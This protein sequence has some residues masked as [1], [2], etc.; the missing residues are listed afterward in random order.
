[1]TK[2]LSSI[3][4][5]RPPTHCVLVGVIALTSGAYAAAYNPAAASFAPCPNQVG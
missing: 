3:S 5:K 2:L 1:M 4:G